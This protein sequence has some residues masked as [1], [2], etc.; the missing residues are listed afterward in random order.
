MIIRCNDQ[1]FVCIIIFIAFVCYSAVAQKKKR[2][3]YEISPDYEGEKNIV[4]FDSINSKSGQLAINI[5]Y[6]NE[7]LG[8]DAY[9][10]IYNEKFSKKLNTDINGKIELSMETGC[11]QIT[12]D[13][14]LAKDFDTQFCLGKKGL[15]INLI[16]ARNI[17]PLGQVY[18]IRSKIKLNKRKLRQIRNCI[19]T[20]ENCQDCREK[21]K[22]SIGI[23]I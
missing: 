11:Y 17:I 23:R 12:F 8:S 1:R 5:K 13:T 6:L 2:F 9:L 3:E 19:Q 10:S 22:V 16:L 14:L 18:I 7:E 20:S 4:A 15:I 21:Y